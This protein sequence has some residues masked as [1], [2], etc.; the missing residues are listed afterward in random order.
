[1]NKQ[2]KLKFKAVDKIA[3][4]EIPEVFIPAPANYIG[5]FKKY[6]DLYKKADSSTDHIFDKSQLA[7]IDIDNCDIYQCKGKTGEELIWEKI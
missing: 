5:F 1:M 6:L 3:N 4:I 2:L 7:W